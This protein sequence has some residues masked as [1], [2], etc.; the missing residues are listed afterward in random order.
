MFGLLSINNLGKFMFIKKY[1]SLVLLLIYTFVN[2]NSLSCSAIEIDKST[3]I[4]RTMNFTSNSTENKLLTGINPIKGFWSLALRKLISFFT[5]SGTLAWSFSQIQSLKYCYEDLKELIWNLKVFFKQIFYFNHIEPN[6]IIADLKKHFET[7][8]GQTKSKN[9]IESFLYTIIHD[10]NLAQL[11]K[12]K[13]NHAD[14]ILM[15]GP[16][17]V[18][19]TLAA[20]EIAK[21]L[22]INPLVLSSA[23]VDLSSSDTIIEQLFGLY[24]EYGNSP[25]KK[26]KILAKYLSAHPRNGVIVINEYDKLNPKGE[27]DEILRAAVDNGI[28]NIKG[29]VFDFSGMLIILT[30]N[31]SSSC[32]NRGNF[33]KINLEKETDNTGSRTIAL[34]DKSF[35]NRI[36]I[37]EFDNLTQ[38]EYFKI[39][40]KEFHKKVI[41]YWE[42]FAGIKLIISDETYKK[43][44]IKAENNNKGARYLEIIRANLV[45]EIIKMMKDDEDFS[46]N[47]NHTFFVYYDEL[48]EKFEIKEQ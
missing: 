44:A 8:E 3:G 25:I 42:K 19:K 39:A 32:I 23:D 17:G 22:K 35:L 38:I 24:S 18:G 12:Y 15:I 21:A 10:K 33:D 14:V 11:N 26:S 13:Y 29:Q 16:S 5:L 48:L 1:I 28:V 46:Q 47:K 20:N 7:I 41:D 43:I 9:T 34:H 37:V 30:S 27:L 36:K 2:I 31:E 6:K 45:R 4:P 40:K